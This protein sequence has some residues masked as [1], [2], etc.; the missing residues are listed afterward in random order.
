MSI[1]II[2]N[3]DQKQIITRMAPSPTGR[4]HVG[5]IRTAFYNYAFARK[6]GGKFILRIEDTDKERSSEEFEK[7]IYEAFAWVG[8]E[9]DEVYRQSEHLARHQELLRQ[10][11]E[12]GYAYEGEAAENGEGN[13]IRFKNPNTSITFDDQILGKIT[14]DTTDLGDFVI[15]RNMESPLYHLAVVIDDYDEGVTHVIRAQEHL[16]NTPRQILILEALGFGRPVYAHVPFILGADG[17]K[18]LSK[19]DGDVAILDYREKGYLPEAMMNFLAFIGW[20]PGGEKEIFNTQ[21]L[22]DLFDLTKVQKGPAGYNI[23][24][25]NWINKEHIKTL[26]RDEQCAAVMPYVEHLDHFDTEVFDRAFDTILERLNVWSDM[27]TMI[28]EGEIQYFF[29][30]QK[31]ETGNLVWKKSDAQH[32]LEHLQAV[33]T[34]IEEYTGAWIAGALKDLLWEYAE[35]HGKGDVLWPLRYAL[36][37]RDRSPDPFVLLFILGKEESSQRIVTA[38]DLLKK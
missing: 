8:M 23:D 32:A 1:L 4:F 21:E 3:T 25:L 26:S 7:E 17:K 34:Q 6:H 28:E 31:Y 18:K 35:E 12:S 16:A 10:L 14:F 29:S 13:V 33:R 11:I 20:N 9:Y 19:R 38:I 2:M 24:K 15:A 36:S 22:V 37:G 5:G 30:P 27:A